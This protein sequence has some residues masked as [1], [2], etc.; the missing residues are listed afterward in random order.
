MPS[1]TVALDADTMIVA[2]DETNALRVYARNK[3]GLPLNGFDF[4]GQLA[5]P[6]ADNPEIDIEGS[7]RIGDR[8]FWTG[9][10]SN[11]K[12][13]H[14]RPNRHRVFATDLAGSG[15][16][17]SLSYVGR[18]DWLLEDMV[19]WDQ[20]NGH[21]LGAN[22]LGLAASSAEGVDSKTPAGFNIEG[23]GMAPDN[24]T[25]YFGFRA[26]QLPTSDRHLALIVPVLNFDTLVTAA[27]P[28]SSPARFGDA[29]AHRSSSTSADAASAASIAMPSGNSSSRRVRPAMRPV[30]RHPISACSR[31]PDSPATRRSIWAST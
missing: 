26:P 3:S 18:Y 21:G 17:A 7:T 29:S 8:L 19:A 10:Y 13:F 9:S 15:I 4:S 25:A 5:L 16:N 30:S 12:N 24:T 20:A 14:V 28:D 1:A 11:S 31:G 6:D 27:A 22:A 23:L 2:D